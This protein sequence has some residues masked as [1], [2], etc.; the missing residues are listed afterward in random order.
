M[1]ASFVCGAMAGFVETGVCH[2]LDTVKTRMQ[3]R[4]NGLAST[5]RSVW[6]RGGFYRGIVPVWAGVIPK[7]AVRF[8]VFDRLMVATE[9][10][11]FVS[12]LGA[13]AVEAVLVVNPS[14]IVKIRLQTAA[15]IRD[16]EKPT[17][18]RIIAEENLRLFTKGVAMTIVRQ[19]SNQATNFF[20]HRRLRDDLGFHTMAAGFIS[21]AIGPILNHPFDLIKTRIQSG[22]SKGG[23]VRTASDIFAKNGPRGF[24]VGL[25]PRLIRIMPGQAVTFTVY[26]SCRCCLYEK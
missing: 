19:S 25:V 26:D 14:D 23:F 7:N 12:G 10:S 15:S 21:G 22:G 2:P 24:Y 4:G 11:S 20:V 16:A 3:V 8:S 1:M 6:D 5:I 9:G 13:G 17:I 18:A